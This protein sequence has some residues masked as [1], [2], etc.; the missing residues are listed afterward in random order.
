RDP[1]WLLEAVVG[2]CAVASAISLTTFIRRPEYL[3]ATGG[4]PAGGAGDYGAG[5]AGPAPAGLSPLRAVESV[6]R[7]LIHYPS[8]LVYVALFDRLPWFLHAYVVINAAYAA[9][10]LAAVAAKLGRGG[11]R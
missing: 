8:Y 7:F 5:L 2:L 9:R 10:S 1:R 4:A 11:G 6:G 3:S